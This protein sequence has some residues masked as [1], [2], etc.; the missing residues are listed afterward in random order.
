[1]EEAV[2]NLRKRCLQENRGYRASFAIEGNLCLISSENALI[3]GSDLSRYS[4]FKI[5]KHGKLIGYWRTHDMKTGSFYRDT[6][7]YVPFSTF[8][9]REKTANELILEISYIKS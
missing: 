8:S 7:F 5:T 1:M 9:V 6:L 2:E 4:H 3:P